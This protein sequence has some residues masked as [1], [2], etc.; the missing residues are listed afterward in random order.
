MQQEHNAMN[1]P[2]SIGVVKETKN[3]P[4][5]RV[6]ITPEEGANILKLFPHVNLFIQSSDSR[7]FSDKEYESKGL[8]VV[9]NLDHCDILIGVKEVAVEK[10]I[11][12]KKYMFFSHTTKQQP[13]NKKLL[14]EILKKNI[15]LIDYEHLTNDSNMRLVAFSRWA[16]II[17]CY[18]GLK[19]LGERLNLFKLKPASQLQH[20]YKMF[21]ELNTAKNL[22]PLKF[23]IT[24]HGRAGTGAQEILTYLE[25]PEVTPKDFLSKN[26]DHAVFSII[27]P[28]EYVER[29][30]GKKFT[31]QHFFNNPAMYRSAFAPYTKVTYLLIS[32]HFWNPHSPV[33]MTGKDMQTDDFKISVIADISCDI[34]GSIPSTIRPS[35][36]E[37][38]IYGYNPFTG[39]ETAPFDKNSVTV[40]AVDNLPGELPR[41]TSSDFSKDLVEKILPSLL[42]EDEHNIIRRATIATNGN[43]TKNY[44]YLKDYA[45]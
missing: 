28:H 6:A 13:Y 4:D 35:T 11:P 33:L 7:C 24:G 38:P 30:D 25:I 26:Y 44:S 41:D 19:A 40:M 39:K 18:N 1:N 20:I 12:N 17:G 45:S 10:L 29:L 23:L 43:L 36:I 42:V 34:N 27:D 21:D 37:K 9:D 2:I 31:L 8:K 22:P 16:G 15:T 5:R 3:P 32:C 14:R